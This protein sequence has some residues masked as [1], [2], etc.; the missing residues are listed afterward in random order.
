M[1]VAFPAVVVD[2]SRKVGPSPRRLDSCCP[3]DWG[4]LQGGIVDVAVAENGRGW[5]F[6]HARRRTTIMRQ[7]PLGSLQRPV[8]VLGIC[9]LPCFVQSDVCA[10]QRV[11]ARSCH[12]SDRKRRDF[13]RTYP[14]R[15]R[16]V[17]LTVPQVREKLPGE[18]FLHHQ[19]AASKKRRREA[20][21]RAHRS[22]R[23]QGAS[24][25]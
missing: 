11:A 6:W 18:R 9:W 20:P 19:R 23:N 16:R 22:S 8:A 2:I 17:L 4:F 3:I 7:Q 13:L 12:P 1:L 15:K 24:N 25:E 14:S 5:R 21:C 10:R